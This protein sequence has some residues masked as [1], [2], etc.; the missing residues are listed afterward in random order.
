[1]FTGQTPSSEPSPVTPVTGRTKLWTEAAISPSQLRRLE[2]A[3][4][5]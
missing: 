2:R 1:M 4:R 5:A 3:V